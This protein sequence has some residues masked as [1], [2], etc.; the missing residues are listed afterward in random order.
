MLGLVV[1]CVSGTYCVLEA[2][3]PKVGKT[4]NLPSRS[5]RSDAVGLKL[6]CASDLLGRT[7]AGPQSS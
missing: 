6:Q 1:V 7:Q 3:E 2:G 4:E 5:L